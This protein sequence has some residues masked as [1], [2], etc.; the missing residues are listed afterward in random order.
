MDPAVIIVS[1]VA[2]VG[3]GTILARLRSAFGG[4][5]DRRPAD[6]AL[7]DPAIG[8]LRHELDA[9]QERLDF[10]ERILLAQKDQRG[11]ALPGEA[12][13]EPN[14]RPRNPA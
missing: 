5:L 6:A 1:V 14:V 3:V 4:R 12:N 8:E 9:V 7:P 13:P 2:T 10:F 11:R